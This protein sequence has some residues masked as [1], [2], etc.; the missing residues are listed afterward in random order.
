[1][2]VIFRK[3]FKKVIPKLLIVSIQLKTV[4]RMIKIKN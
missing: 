2:N 3:Y 1:M 4:T